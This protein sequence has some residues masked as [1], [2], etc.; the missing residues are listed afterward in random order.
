MEEPIHVEMTLSLVK[1]V[2]YSKEGAGR[3]VLVLMELFRFGFDDCATGHIT[4]I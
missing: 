4:H 3:S 1:W 2:S